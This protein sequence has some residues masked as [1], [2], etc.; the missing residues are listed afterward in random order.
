[1]ECHDLAHRI[2]RAVRDAF[3]DGTATDATIRRIVQKEFSDSAYR[4]AKLM[5]PCGRVQDVGPNVL[6]RC[7][8]PLGHEGACGGNL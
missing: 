8:R 7:E 2:R 1:M 4:V 3:E 6:R 5:R